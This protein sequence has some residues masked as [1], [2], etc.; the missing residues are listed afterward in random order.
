MLRGTN[1][2]TLEDSR[3]RSRS[4]VSSSS[5]LTSSAATT[6]RSTSTTT[7]SLRYPTVA[8]APPCPPTVSNISAGNNRQPS[9]TTGG[10]VEAPPAPS[11]PNNHA[12]DA[13]KKSNKK[14]NDAVITSVVGAGVMAFAGAV[15]YVFGS[16]SKAKK[17]KKRK[18]EENKKKKQQQQ[19]EKRQQQKQGKALKSNND[20]TT[21]ESDNMVKEGN[22]QVTRGAPTINTT[23]FNSEPATVHSSASSS[24]EKQSSSGTDAH[25]ATT[26]EI[27]SLVPRFEGDLRLSNSELSVGTSPS[28]GSASNLGSV[29]NP[30]SV[31]STPNSD[32]FLDFG[33]REVSIKDL[34]LDPEPFSE[35]YFSKVHR[36]D[37][38]GMDVAVK[39]AKVRSASLQYKS[40]AVSSI[41]YMFVFY[42]CPMLHRKFWKAMKA[43]MHPVR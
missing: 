16:S 10:G 7:H 8:A 30:Q 37:Y 22:G 3:Y 5:S 24:L 29:T 33:N 28:E 27:T 6:G 1:S 38:E 42:S 12:S 40:L 11:T 15:G 35:G 41:L 25:P 34:D 39:F 20:S 9:V 32:R 31:T 21:K 36:G 17:K 4:T 14:T 2:A 13:G 23:T 18:E 26:K 43:T 19:L